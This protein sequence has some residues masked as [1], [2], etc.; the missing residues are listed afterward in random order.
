MSRDLSS[1]SVN[2]TIKKI[3]EM[4]EI[5]QY[6]KKTLDFLITNSNSLN[7]LDPALI[8]DL[9]LH[10][11]E[12]NTDGYNTNNFGVAITFLELAIFNTYFHTIYKKPLSPVTVL[13]YGY[14]DNVGR[15]NY[16]GSFDPTMGWWFQLKLENF[17][18]EF[19]VNTKIFQDQNRTLITE[20]HVTCKIPIQN[21]EL[22]NFVNTIKKLAFNNSEY[23]GKCI[24]VK[25]RESSFKGIEIIQIPE[26]T[27]KLIL[28]DTQQKYISHFAN[29]VRK[30]GS[31]RYL[32]NGEPGTGKT[33]SIR[34]IVKQL[35]PDVTFVMPDFSTSDD[36]TTILEACEIFDRC[37]IIMDDIDL[38]LGSRDTGNYTRLL[39][40][41]LSFFDGVKKRKVSLLASTNDK[42]LVDKAAERPGRF[43]MTLDY[44]FLTPEQIIEVCKVHLPEQY[45]TK[46]IYDC[47]SGKINGRTANITGAFIANLAENIKEMSDDDPN[48][49]IQETISLITESYKGFY[50]S[51]VEKQKNNIGFNIG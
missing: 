45:H 27:N 39:G 37:V 8:T 6:N 43:N 11:L 42:G 32:L 2:K 50:M 33:D 44:T 38:Y 4:G 41:F 3:I 13:N 9:D 29:R 21:T 36:L 48:W 34:D 16:G 14:C 15:V 28:S 20:L 25:L 49:T 30:G 18:N 40:E 22:E 35:I 47:L 5:D 24:K 51:Q 1:T 12:E 31:V 17:E 19:I 10:E 46:E 23:A 26:R 7:G